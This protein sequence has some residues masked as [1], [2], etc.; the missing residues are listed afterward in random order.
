MRRLSGGQS[1]K[2]TVETFAAFL[3]A[4]I[5]K[6]RE[7]SEHEAFAYQMDVNR[8][9]YI[10]VFDLETCIGNLNNDRFY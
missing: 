5:D 4:K 9:G 3:K 1:T 8:D 10:D 6:K 7:L 2:V